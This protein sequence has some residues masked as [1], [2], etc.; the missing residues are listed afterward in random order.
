VTRTRVCAHASEPKLF[1]SV[2][3]LIVVIN[4]G[5][6]DDLWETLNLVGRIRLRTMF[7]GRKCARVDV[8]VRVDFDGGHVDATVLEDGA[9]RAGDDAFAD[10]ADDT[11][12]H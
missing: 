6:R 12:G 5:R 8:D 10:A 9:E 1:W 11:A 3:N 2:R 4:R 7:V